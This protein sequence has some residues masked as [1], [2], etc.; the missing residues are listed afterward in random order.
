MKKHIAVLILAGTISMGA[1]SAAEIFAR[2]A[3]PPPVRMGA[4]G[5]APRLGYVWVNGYQEWRG[6]RYIWRE[7]RWMRPRYPGGAWVEP[8]WERRRDGYGFVR[9][10]WRR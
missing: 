1:A 2:V 4:V 6:G 3:P 7:G 8:R 10:Y 5:V 9:G